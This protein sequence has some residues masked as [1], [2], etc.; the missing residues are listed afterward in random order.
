MS[1]DEESRP[2]RPARRASASELVRTDGFAAPADVA[3]YI[4]DIASELSA[5]AKATDLPVLS[6]ILAVAASEAMRLAK[7]DDGGAGLTSGSGDE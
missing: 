6:S 5:L 4:A 3:S 1:K 7:L 2:I